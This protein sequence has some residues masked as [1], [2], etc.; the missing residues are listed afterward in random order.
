M[1]HEQ[2]KTRRYRRFLRAAAH[3]ALMV[4]LLGATTVA[5]SGDDPS[6]ASLEALRTELVS[7]QLT[8]IP[9][10]FGSFLSS[11]GANHRPACWVR[12]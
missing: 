5:R 10:S 2:L 1:T 9:C 8:H 6:A 4:A 3:A 12:S 11:Q 7:A